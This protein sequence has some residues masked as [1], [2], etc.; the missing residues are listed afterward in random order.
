M[1]AMSAPTEQAAVTLTSEDAQLLQDH[2][3]QAYHQVRA[4]LDLPP[5][6]WKPDYDQQ[7]QQRSNRAGNACCSGTVCTRPSQ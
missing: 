7:Q 3:R 5:T 6:K 1:I 4:D 2:V